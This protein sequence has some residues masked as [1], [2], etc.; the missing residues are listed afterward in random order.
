MFIAFFSAM[1][2]CLLVYEYILPTVAEKAILIN[3]N[4]SYGLLLM[5][6]CCYGGYKYIYIFYWAD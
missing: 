1:W 2:L 3:Y 6:L 4:S 5:H